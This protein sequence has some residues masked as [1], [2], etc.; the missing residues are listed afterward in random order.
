MA[1]TDLAPVAA[2]SQQPRC[3][4]KQENE[5]GEGDTDVWWIQ[6]V[7]WQMLPIQAAWRIPVTKQQEYLLL[8]LATVAE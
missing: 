1:T 7:G 8:E 2:R 3:N 6:A 4:R 5:E